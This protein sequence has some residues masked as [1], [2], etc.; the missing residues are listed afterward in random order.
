MKLSSD[1]EK[2]IRHW[3]NVW[4]LDVP[5]I[6]RARSE[7]MDNAIAY[8]D[9]RN[10]VINKGIIGDNLFTK[11]AVLHELRH[12]YQKNVYP[13][14]YNW[15]SEHTDLYNL[16]YKLPF[17]VIEED[18]RIFSYTLGN[19]DGE[20][21]LKMINI[22]TLNKVIDL[23]PDKIR[24]RIDQINY[25]FK[26]YCRRNNLFEYKKICNRLGINS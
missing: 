24:I 25:R 17:C 26:D 9:N 23:P 10:I 1:I 6:A 7:D 15:W 22:N 5:P 21:L 14:I 20:E 16:T 3:C 2:S 4:D 18:A 8:F 12:Y 11:M 19:Q 13:E